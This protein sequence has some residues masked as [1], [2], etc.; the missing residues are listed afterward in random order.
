MNLKSAVETAEPIA[1]LLVSV[2][3]AARLLSLSRSTVENLVAR[4]EIQSL[5]VGR[6][7]LLTVAAIQAFIRHQETDDAA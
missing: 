6:R 1:P 3:E 7:R 2:S 4:N 5:K